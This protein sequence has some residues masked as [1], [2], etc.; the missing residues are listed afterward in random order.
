MAIGCLLGYSLAAPPIPCQPKTHTENFSGSIRSRQCLNASR[1]QINMEIFQMSQIVSTLAGNMAALLESRSA[2]WRE[3]AYRIAEGGALPGVLELLEAGG[4]LGVP[5]PAEA[6]EEDVAA[7][8]KAETL[9]VSLEAKWARVAE[10]LR[11][12][13]GDPRN[14]QAIIDKRKDEIKGLEEILARWNW[15]KCPQSIA[16]ELRQFQARYPR[17]WGAAK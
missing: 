5:S 3:W 11:P 14:I 16:Q 13:D 4:I 10:L 15:A 9:R 2:T 8:G 12:F 6:L 7:I 17:V 1:V